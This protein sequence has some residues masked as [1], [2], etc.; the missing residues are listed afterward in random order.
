MNLRSNWYVVAVALLFCARTSV[1]V[2][3]DYTVKFNC[4]NS[5]GSGGC[6][7][8]FGGTHPGIDSSVFNWYQWTSL[9]AAKGSRIWNYSGATIKSFHVKINGTNDTFVVPAGAGGVLFDEVWRKKDGKEVLFNV[10]SGGAGIANNTRFWSYVYPQT[11]GYPQPYFLGKAFS[12]RQPNPDPNDWE[13]V[14]RI[15]IEKF[16]EEYRDVRDSATGR[17]GDVFIL[18]NNE[19]LSWNRADGELRAV[20]MGQ[21][22]PFDVEQVK[23]ATD[24][25]RKSEDL[26]LC[27]E[28]QDI[29]KISTEGLQL[30]PKN[31]LLK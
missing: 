7:K 13:M 27:R 15:P 17:N 28:G 22:I 6:T 2:A 4:W 12:D 16:P 20:K 24:A 1:S 18:A 3:K 26:V 14:P 11:P 8:E 19:V 9:G 30:W 23:I 10:K 31:L 21:T 29:I 5:S 25:E